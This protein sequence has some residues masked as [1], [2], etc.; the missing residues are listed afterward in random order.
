VTWKARTAEE[1]DQQH[2]VSESIFYSNL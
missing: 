1:A 2:I